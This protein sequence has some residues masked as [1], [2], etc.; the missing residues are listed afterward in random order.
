MTIDRRTLLKTGGLTALAS[1]VPG[2]SRSEREAAAPATA[3]AAAPQSA[4]DYTLRIGTGLVELAPDRI[5]A[6]TVYNKQF[7]GPLIRLKEGKAVTVD[8]YN[9]TDTSEQLHWHGQTVPVDV[10]GSAE[11]GTPFI[12]AHGHRRITFTP[13]PSGLRFYHTHLIAGADLRAGQYGGQVGPVYIEPSHDPGAYDREVFLTLKEFEPAFSR[14]GDMAMDFLAP[15]DPDRTLRE[16]GE[17]AMHAS[18]AKGAPHGYEVGYQAFSINGR[19]LGQGEPIRVKSGERVLLHIVNGSATEIRS[20][21]LPGHTFRVVALDGNALAAPVEVPVLWLGTAE[22]I[23]AI[24]E[25]RRPGVWVLGD[26]GDDRNNGMGVVVEYAGATGKPAWTPPPAFKWDYTR[27]G[28]QGWTPPPVDD[29]IEMTFTKDNAALDGFNQWRING[30]AFSM[31]NRTP[32]F[33]LR[34]GARY[35]LRM[36]NA[37]DDI[38]PIHLHRQSFEIVTVAGRPAGGVV[39]DV[40]MLNGY[41]VMEVDFTAN[42]T[43]LSLF[44]CHQQVHMDFGFMALFDCR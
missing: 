21:A 44:H 6:T 27:F 34:H 37:T 13:G 1:F 43:G 42:A 41:Q 19:M 24:V 39:K 25:M 30:T 14:G 15:A 5:V 11:E 20:L 28:R 7:P 32:L 22:R 29:T 35:R 40:A 2:C 33:N 10:D 31:E 23:S 18:L 36:R 3:P 38:H 16:Q 26:T 12:P 17:S 8:L 9:D 4:A